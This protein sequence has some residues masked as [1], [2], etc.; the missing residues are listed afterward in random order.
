MNLALRRV[1]KAVGDACTQTPEKL[2]IYTVMKSDADPLDFASG[3]PPEARIPIH[4]IRGRG[5]ATATP[6]RFAKDARTVV[7]DGWDFPWD[8]EAQATPQPTRVHLETARSALC[9]N[10]SPDIFFE[11]SVNP[12]RGCEHGCVYCYARPTHS[13]LNLSPGLD[14]ETQI[15]AKHNIAEVLRAELARP[16]HVPRMLNIGSATD[17]YQPAERE[18]RLTRGVIEVLR[19]ARHPFSL[20]TK[21]SGVERDLDLLAPLAAQRLAAVYVTITTLDAALARRLEPR[22]AAPHRRL[23]TI[24]ALADAG[25]PVG[26]SVAPQIPFITEDM[27]QVLA[28]AHEA[29]ARSAFYTVIRLPWELDAL[30]REWLALHYPQRAA[31]V[32]ARVQDL[33]NLS[34]A[35]R[36]AGKTYDSNYITRMKGSGLWADLL[37]Q[38][39]ATTCRKL[40][41]NRERVELD[42]AQFR[43]GLAQGQ[44]SLF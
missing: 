7:D 21:S 20:I 19:D 28:A 11:H 13:Y 44:G 8:G 42:L 1:V 25:V 39:F 38:R 5:A 17:C 30:F 14:F 22:A 12:Y 10:D 35:Q 6:H 40:G 27:E 9:A 23:R 16:G 2:Y 24:R 37:R 31:R 43:P 36:G 18:L 32:M 3:P 41:L 34:N 29:G 26:V 33:H 15:I 4:A